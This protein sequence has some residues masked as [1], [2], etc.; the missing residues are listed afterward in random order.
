MNIKIR[1]QGYADD[2][3]VRSLLIRTFGSDDEA[4]L[5]ERLQEEDADRISFVALAEDK[6]VGQILFSPVSFDNDIDSYALALAPLAVLPQYQGQGIGSKLVR[7]GLDQAIVFRYALVFV[8]GAPGY[9]HRFGFDTAA[10]HNYFCDYDVPDENF[11]VNFLR[12]KPST[13]FPAVVSYS[14][15]FKNLED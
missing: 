9:F 11:M 12:F 15:A 2:P 10:K 14:P 8:L 7:R 1:E 3:A 6:I 4:R 13:Q 5:M